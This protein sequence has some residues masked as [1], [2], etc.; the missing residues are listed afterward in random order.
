MSA[1]ALY[2]LSSPISKLLL[3]AVPPMMMAAFMY[4]GAGLGLSMTELLRR[5]SGA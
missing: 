3:N 2:A 1:A 4:L 5:A